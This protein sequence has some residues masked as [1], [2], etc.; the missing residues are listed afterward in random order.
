MCHCLSEPSVC[1]PSSSRIGGH[2]RIW[3]Y[4]SLPNRTWLSRYRGLKSQP[5]IRSAAIDPYANQP[6]K[7]GNRSSLRDRLGEQAACPACFDEIITLQLPHFDYVKERI[8]ANA[9]IRVKAFWRG[10]LGAR[11]WSMGR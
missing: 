5:G 10:W 1:L 7:A 8:Q 6:D 9:A 11:G 4:R 2:S 3:K